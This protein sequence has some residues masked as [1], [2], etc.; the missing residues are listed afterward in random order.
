MAKELPIKNIVSFSGGKDST[1]LILWAL[2]NLKDFD[3]VWMDT[4]WEHPWTYKYVDYIDQELLSGELIRL[5]SSKYD[6]FEDMSIQKKRVPST[7][8]RFCTQKL[9]LEPLIAFFDTIRDEFEIHNFIG[10]RADESFARSKMKET[11]FDLDYYGCWIQRPLLK[12][13]A[14]DVFDMMDKHNIEPNPLYKVGMNRV[15]CMP[16]VMNRHSDI[17]QIIKR[18]PEVID[19]VRNLEEKLGRSFFP[20]N[21]IP[22]RYCS[23]FQENEIE[24]TKVIN[25]P[26]FG[27]REV[28]V[29]KKKTSWY[30]MIDDV[31]KYLEDNPDQTDIEDGEPQSCMSH[32]AICE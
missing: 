16:C 27:K 9:K 11:T 21:Y 17:K 2:E 8:A 30:P 10:I 4:G 1:A 32:Y 22:D 7:K 26:L 31:V 5:K 13:K 15:G 29:T 6:G 14:Q 25:D 20:P 28:T 23:Q 19:R 18:F 24:V 12:W 3:T